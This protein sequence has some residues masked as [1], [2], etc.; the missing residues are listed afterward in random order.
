[1]TIHINDLVKQY[2]LAKMGETKRTMRYLI[3]QSLSRGTRK[4][5]DFIDDTEYCTT[6]QIANSLRISIYNASNRVRYLKWCGLLNSEVASDN[7]KFI[8]SIHHD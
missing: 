1:M 8:Y 3:V 4:V 7:G 2:Q 5:F 6:R